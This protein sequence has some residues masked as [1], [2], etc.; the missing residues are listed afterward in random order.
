MAVALEV[1]AE[2]A[3]AQHLIEVHEVGVDVAVAHQLIEMQE[4]AVDVMVEVTME[5]A[6]EMSMVHLL[7]DDRAHRLDYATRVQ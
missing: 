5:A 7:M 3:V 1:A 4:I 6:L 2:V